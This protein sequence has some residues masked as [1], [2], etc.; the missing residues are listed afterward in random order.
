M[1]QPQQ[2]KAILDFEMNGYLAN[3]DGRDDDY[4]GNIQIPKNTIF[5]ELDRISSRTVP[6]KYDPIVSCTINGKNYTGIQ[7]YIESELNTEAYDEQGKP[8]TKLFQIIPK[9]GRVNRRSTKKNS[10]RNRRNS[11]SR[12]SRRK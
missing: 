7:L 5:T 2:Y 6:H 4:I 11:R 12:F 10:I 9:G 8:Y 3:P 1:T